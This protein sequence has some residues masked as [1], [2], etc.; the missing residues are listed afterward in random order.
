MV[1]FNKEPLYFDTWED[2]KTPFTYNFFWIPL[3]YFTLKF[4]TKIQILHS[5][6][7]SKLK[8]QQFFS[9]KRQL[10]KAKKRE[11]KKNSF[12]IYE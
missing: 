7:T 8:K 12:I 1:S 6:K 2:I 11:I 9:K 10:K 5:K 3:R 4:K